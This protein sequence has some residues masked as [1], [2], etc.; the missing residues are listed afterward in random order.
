MRNKLITKDVL[1]ETKINQGVCLILSD[2]KN[3]CE[4]LKTLLHY[5]YKI[6]AELLT[7]DTS[8]KKRTD[9]T[10]RLNKG[11]VK[12]LIAT[13][14]LI[15]EGFDCDNLS[16]LF[17]ATPIK[18]SGRVLQYL[19]RVLRPSQGKKYAR[20]YDYVDENV[21]VLQS[22]AHSRQRAYGNNTIIKE[23]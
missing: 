23:T 3:H 12:V 16:T 20:V 1:K 22:A 9:I 11:E 6:S 7:G 18:F 15:G 19:G 2:R 13:G 5:R 10:K 14:Q 8:V 21:P 4:N 17:L